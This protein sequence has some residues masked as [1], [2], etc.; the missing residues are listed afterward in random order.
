MKLQKLRDRIEPAGMTLL[1]LAAGIVLAA[2]G[3]MKATNFPEWKQN[4]VQMGLPLPDV[5]A[6]L[7]VA[8]E[9]GGGIGLILGAL[10]PLAALGTLAV[11]LTAILKVH[12][13]NGLFAQNNGFEFPFVL[14]WVSLYFV[15]RGG[16]PV[17]IDA[18]FTRR[19][20]A[21]GPGARPT[22][23]AAEAGTPA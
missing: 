7:A 11:M 10:T 19:T 21:A 1:R 5:L 14:L 15:I 13:G 9:L 8:G 12:A 2:H 23:P 22:G 3:W 20:T 6:P 4:V 17:S 18:L 16:G